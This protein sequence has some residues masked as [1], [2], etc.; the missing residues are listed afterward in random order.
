M[1]TSVK[2]GCLET[3]SFL[4][5]EELSDPKDSTERS[6]KIALARV[7][8]EYFDDKGVIIDRED[9]TDL[10]EAAKN[11]DIDFV[12]EFAKK[13]IQDISLTESKSDI[14]F[15]FYINASDSNG[16]TALMHA[17]ANGH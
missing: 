11:G 1:D 9:Q 13:Y 16:M 7:N 12:L 2:F 8:V 5:F 10:I 3:L 17:A 4:L 6:I 15:L 14:V